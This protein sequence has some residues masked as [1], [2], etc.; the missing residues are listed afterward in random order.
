MFTL[1]LAGKRLIVGR[2]LLG[3]MEGYREYASSWTG[4]NAQNEASL[5]WPVLQK[6]LQES[7]QEAVSQ[8]AE[9]ILDKAEVKGA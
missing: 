3:A 8:F 9:K 1:D 6:A 2:A 7:V 5:L 4:I